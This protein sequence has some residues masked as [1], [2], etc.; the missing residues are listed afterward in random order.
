MDA[1]GPFVRKNCHFIEGVT[2]QEAVTKIPT[3]A[4][5]AIS[6]ADHDEVQRRYPIGSMLSDKI[7][8]AIPSRISKMRSFLCGLIPLPGLNFR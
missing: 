6:A 7:N 3:I 8:A 5:G 2:G 1:F 4:A